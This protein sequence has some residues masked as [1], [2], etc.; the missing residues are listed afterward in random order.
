MTGLA[1]R[2]AD[3]QTGARSASRRIWSLIRWVVARGCGVP[4]PA[5]FERPVEDEL[6]IRLTYS[7]EPFRVPPGTLK[8]KS[9]VYN[10]VPGRPKAVSLFGSKTTP[11]C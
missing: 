8:E 1:L 10:F 11:G 2:T 3:R 9:Y 4:G 5:P 7:S 6:V